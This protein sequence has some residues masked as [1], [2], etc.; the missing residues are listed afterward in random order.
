MNMD[1][2]AF[3]RYSTQA[4][5]ALCGL[6]D[7]PQEIAALAGFGDAM[8]SLNQIPQ[9]LKILHCEAA[10]DPTHEPAHQALAA[11]LV[12]GGQ[13]R[14]GRDL[15]RSF[16]SRC[17]VRPSQVPITAGAP[18]VV[19]A[20]GFDKTQIILTRRDD[21]ALTSTLRGGH[22]STNDLLEKA[23][24]PVQ[25]YTITDESLL[26]PGRMPERTLILNSIAEPD[27]EG[28]S[29]AMLKRYLAANP[30]TLVINHP[31]AV[32]A[33]ARDANYVRL[34][35]SDGIHF[36]R[37]VRLNFE[38]ATGEDVT[39]A[40][41]GRGFSGPVIIR[42]VGTQTGRTVGL[43]TNLDDPQAYI[44]T[45]PDQRL[46]GEFYVITYRDLCIRPAMAWDFT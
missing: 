27:V 45:Y 25:Q 8:L 26:H 5:E 22:F 38:Q 14:Q 35:G 24:F 43:I 2:P 4:T 12:S 37:T 40:I 19:K 11:I 13:V 21:N 1:P 31:E 23:D 18:V 39:D 15:M 34:M 32:I 7:D 46:S 29:L 17:P 36:P 41:T 3:L 20:R 10:A 44:E 6:A 28:A 33:T 9:A 16:F 30:N 42:E